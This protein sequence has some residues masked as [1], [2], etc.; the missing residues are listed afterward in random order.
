MLSVPD[1]AETELAVVDWNPSGVLILQTYT[2]GSGRMGVEGSKYTVPSIQWLG[3]RGSMLHGVPDNVLQPLTDRDRDLINSL[4]SGP[5][6]QNG[7]WMEELEAMEELGAK[8]ELEALY[9]KYGL[10]GFVCLLAEQAVAA[11]QHT[12]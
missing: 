6:A 5:S 3:V 2:H 1:R 4:R 9:E 12:M 10:G 7:T 11:M 8:A